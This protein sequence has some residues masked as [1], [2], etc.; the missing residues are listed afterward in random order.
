MTR[1]VLLPA[2]SDPFLNAYW[3]RHYLP[4]ADTV[5]ELHMAVCGPLPAE[6][7]AYTRACVE[8]V[9]HATLYHLTERT[10]HGEVIAYLLTKTTADHIMLAEDDAFVRIPR[11]VADA[12]AEAESGALAGCPR[13]SYASTEVIEAAELRLGA[14]AGGLAFWPCFL[15]VSRESLEATDR[16]F[17]ATI[18]EAGDLLFDH[19][20][21]ELGTADT[22]VWA[23][24]QLRDQ[25]LSVVLRDMHRVESPDT[26]SGPWF[27][28]G[29]LSSGHGFAW[30]G[31]LSADRYAQEV[32][33][34]GRLTEGDAAKRMAWWQ[35]A[36]D[37]WDGGIPEY[38]AAYETGFRTFMADIGLSQATVDAQRA[39]YDRLVTWA[40]S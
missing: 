18:W 5:D 36:W 12:F 8:A 10:P 15:F 3:L 2:G 7:I 6:V 30:L 16:H 27:H 34:F 19:T 22:F 4:W 31:E 38:H 23:S 28:V 14:E 35:R 26:A 21:T 25:G 37:N 39:T 13:N 24:Y 33:Q 1:A 11:V 17:E 20:M 29:S 40:E 32:E 9:P